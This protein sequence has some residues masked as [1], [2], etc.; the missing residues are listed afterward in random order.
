MSKT[1]KKR[2]IT[3]ALGNIWRMMRGI[4]RG[5]LLSKVKNLDVDGF[6]ITILRVNELDAIKIS[7]AQCR[8]L[9]KF[10][11]V[12]IHAPTHLARKGEVSKEELL[13]RMD[14]LYELYKKVGAQNIVI[15]PDDL[16]DK[17]ILK[18]YKMNYSTENM[19]H[20]RG[21]TKK[22]VADILRKNPK[23]GLCLDVSHAHTISSKETKYYVDN[24]REK[25]TQVHFSGANRKGRHLQMKNSAK[26]FMKSMKPILSLDVPIIIEENMPFKKM[27]QVK[28][29][30]KIVKNIL[31]SK[32]Y[33]NA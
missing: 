33:K 21:I 29:E 19:E 9:K 4:D 1:D 22:H 20:G 14:T 26:S 3:F 30:I 2:V 5:K 7:D 8:W 32:Q 23:I 24:F 10:H 27:E 17:S 31:N 16:P 13:R 6:E 25:I 12:S 28:R 15:H 11:Y 18:R